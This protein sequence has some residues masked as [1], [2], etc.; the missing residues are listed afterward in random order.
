MAKA[1]LNQLTRQL[2][3]EL[4]DAGIRVNTALMG[5]MMG[6]TQKNLAAAHVGPDNSTAF[7]AKQARRYRLVEFHLTLTA[8]R[9]FISFCLKSQVPPWMSMEATGSLLNRLLKNASMGRQ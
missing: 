4:A 9:Q 3:I 6:A 1:A 2:A 7:Y 5:R 8:P